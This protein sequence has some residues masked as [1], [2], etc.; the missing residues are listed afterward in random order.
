MIR[1]F[2]P[3]FW[4]KKLK[5]KITWLGHA[6]R[7]KKGEWTS[8]APS[9]VPS[10]PLPIRSLSYAILSS[11]FLLRS[12]RLSQLSSSPSLPH[13]ASV[14]SSLSFFTSRSLS[15]SLRHFHGRSRSHCFGHQ[16]KTRARK[17]NSRDAEIKG[18]LFFNG[19]IIIV[20]D[21]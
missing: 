12:S 20:D 19:Q 16:F 18:W 7:V 15:L 1:G 2:H 14:S 21:G 4:K 17:T 10:R 6:G 3:N 11:V 5:F 13:Q 9:H 8:S